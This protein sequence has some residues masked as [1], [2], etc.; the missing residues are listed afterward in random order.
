M[1]SHG[2][3]VTFQNSLKPSGWESCQASQRASCAPN[4]SFSFGGGSWY[5]AVIGQ[6]LTDMGGAAI[7]YDRELQ[8]TAYTV[9]NF[10]LSSFT[11]KKY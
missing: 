8:K 6:T 2:G 11:W 5:G 3:A 10:M 9:G 1:E 7:H 4:A